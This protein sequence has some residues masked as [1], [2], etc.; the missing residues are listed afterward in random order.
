LTTG[1]ALSAAIVNLESEAS[2]G[3]LRDALAR[4]LG[5]STLQLAFL[6]A[7]GTG[8]LDTSGQAVEVSRPDTGRAVV[9]VPARTGRSWSTTRA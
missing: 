7:D 8:Y 2:P 4:A 1:G 5:D 9:P 3:R 6:Q